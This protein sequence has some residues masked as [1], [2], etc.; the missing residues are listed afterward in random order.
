MLPTI[1]DLLLNR[2]VTL[3]DGSVWTYR[4]RHSDEA[5]EAARAREAARKRAA[6]RRQKQQRQGVK[7]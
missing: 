3:P 6:W 7:D 4:R 2:P 1:A 5:A